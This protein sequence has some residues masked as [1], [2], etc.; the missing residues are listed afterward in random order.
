VIVSK[1]VYISSLILYGWIDGDDDDDYDES[2]AD[3]LFFPFRY[4]MIILG[5]NA[6]FSAFFHTLNLP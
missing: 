6:L 5:E 1:S 2:G 3:S 4:M